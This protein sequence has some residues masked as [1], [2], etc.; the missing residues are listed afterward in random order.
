MAIMSVKMFAQQMIPG[1]KGF[2]LT[3]YVFPQFPE[4]QNYALSAGVISY[5]KNGNYLFGLA[6]YSRKSYE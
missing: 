3:Y 6:E 4:K 2:E 5:V 1:Q